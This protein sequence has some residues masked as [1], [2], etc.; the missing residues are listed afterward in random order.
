MYITHIIEGAKFRFCI[1]GMKCWFES[2]A[3]CRKYGMYG[4]GIPDLKSR[5]YWVLYPLRDVMKLEPG[6][7]GRFTINFS[8]MRAVQ[9]ERKELG[10]FDLDAPLFLYAVDVSGKRY[11]IDSG[12]SPNSFVECGTTELIRVSQLTGKPLREKD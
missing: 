2:K 5:K 3:C 7:I 11:K 10:I 8:K 1:R 4:R 12:A 9:E 6:E